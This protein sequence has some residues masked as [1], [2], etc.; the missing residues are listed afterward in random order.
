MKLKAN[1]VPMQTFTRGNGIA[2]TAPSRNSFNKAH[3][4]QRTVAVNLNPQ[5]IY[6]NATAPELQHSVRIAEEYRSEHGTDGDLVFEE[7]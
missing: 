2:A 1:S 4:S 3:F 7:A 5:V 6:V